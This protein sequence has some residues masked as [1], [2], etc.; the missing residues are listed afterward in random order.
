MGAAFVL[1]VLFARY[2][3][4]SASGQVFYLFTLFAF[5]T[6]FATLSL[7]S[8]IGFYS[9][10]NTIHPSQLLGL[11]LA[12]SFLTSALI[13]VLFVP[14]SA[15]F[16]VSI[17][18]PLYYPAAYILGNMLISFGN[19]YCYSRY[20]FV[21]PGLLAVT[22]N[23]LLIS[24]LLY[25][26]YWGI[27][28]SFITAYFLSFLVQGVVLFISIL[29]RSG[30]VPSF[31][32][33]LSRLKNIFSYSL[34]AYLSN[35]LFLV[36]SRV[37]YLFVKKYCSPAD[38][39]N[40]IQVS[41]IAQLFFILP[42]MIAAVLFPVIAGNFRPAIAERLRTISAMVLA[43]YG[44]LLVMLACMGKWL[45]PWLFGEGFDKMY[46]PFV[47]LIPGILAISSLYPYTAYYAAVNRIKINVYGAMLALSFIVLCDLLFIPMY[48]IGAAALVSSVGYMIF[49]VYILSEFRKEFQLPLKKLFTLNRKEYLYII[50]RFKW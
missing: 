30:T 35:L 20:Y 25:A 32:F 5:I 40:Y 28:S 4:A 42:S 10:K 48:G 37:D 22:I 12:W 47:L 15:V 31:S 27:K 41:R 3:S 50:Q 38:L 13:I 29:C 46:L 8:G 49:Q 43:A 34:R 39:G 6:Q 7:E 19:A 21:L 18:Y 44:I 9:A 36:M 45:F 2:F 24:L 16:S 11:S 26:E 33:S 14:L 23:I 1:N 17:H